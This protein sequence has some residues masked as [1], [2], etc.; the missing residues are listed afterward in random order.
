LD[1]GREGV[2]TQGRRLRPEGKGDDFDLQ[3][4]RRGGGKVMKEGFDLLKKGGG[5]EGERQIDRGRKK[6]LKGE[7]YLNLQ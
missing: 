7:E 6:R 4:K 3:L 2:K 1:V 5:K